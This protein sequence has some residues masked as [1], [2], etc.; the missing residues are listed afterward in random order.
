MFSRRGDAKG[1]S[2]SAGESCE[3]PAM[4]FAGRDYFTVIPGFDQS[5]RLMQI[6]LR[7]A[8]IPPPTGASVRVWR[9][10]SHFDE[11]LGHPL[12]WHW[13]D[14]AGDDSNRFLLKFTPTTDE[15]LD[16]A[17]SILNDGAEVDSP[18]VWDREALADSIRAGYSRAWIERYV[19]RMITEGILV[20]PVDAS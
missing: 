14:L 2:R 11:N 18:D 10:Y 3:G 7:P 6:E 15:L 20:D 4:K 5:G 8:H 16:R 13:Y 17:M 12:G 1:L 19:D 9:R